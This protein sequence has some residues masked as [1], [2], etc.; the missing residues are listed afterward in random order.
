MTL[1]MLYFSFYCVSFILLVFILFHL[2]IF[3]IFLL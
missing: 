3:L 1:K 2:N